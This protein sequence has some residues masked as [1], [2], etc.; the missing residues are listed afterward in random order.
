MEKDRIPVSIYAEMTPNPAVMKFVSNKRMIDLEHVEYHN[1]EEA[2]N[3]P[4]AKKTKIR[5][6]TQAPAQEEMVKR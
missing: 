3:S 5:L 1:I 2:R 6:A 4:L